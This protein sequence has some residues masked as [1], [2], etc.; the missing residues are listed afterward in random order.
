MPGIA[1]HAAQA[2]KRKVEGVMTTVSEHR[3]LG[4]L[5]RKAC[6]MLKVTELQLRKAVAAPD[7]LVVMAEAAACSSNKFPDLEDLPPTQEYP[8]FPDAPCSSASSARTPPALVATRRARVFQLLFKTFSGPLLLPAAQGLNR[9]ALFRS[10]GTVAR[11]TLPGQQQL[12]FQN[13]SQASATNV[14][15]GITI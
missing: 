13:F 2:I 14:I 11:V 7:A 9:G 5:V 15:C 8:E 10:A 6:R 4:T 3:D 1:A 12:F